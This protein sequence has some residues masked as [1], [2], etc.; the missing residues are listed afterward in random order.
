MFTALHS[1]IVTKLQELL[2]DHDQLSYSIDVSRNK[3]GKSKGFAV[4]IEA[5][6]P[7][8]SDVGR[9]TL[10]TTIQIQLVDTYGP[11]RNTDA[12]QLLASHALAD[13]CLIV[14]EGLSA[15]KLNS[16]GVRNVTLEELS[17]PTYVDGEKTVF[18][19][20][21]IEANLKV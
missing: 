21:T 3:L 15:A 11:E 2:P 8:N 14:F 4:T 20:L 5:S 17:E 12:A 18:R 10:F 16:P 7:T 13:R 1:N 19:T 9:L 6:K